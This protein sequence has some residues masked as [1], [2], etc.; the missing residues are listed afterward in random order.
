MPER[1]LL[2]VDQG[3]SATKAVI[4]GTGGAIRA[5]ASVEVVSSYPR[6]GFVEQ[7]PRDIHR[8]VLEAVGRCL[9][10]MRHEG[11][12]PGEIAACG[13]SNQRET[14]VLWDR[15]GEPLSPAVV[16]QC[17]RSV[18]I[19]ERLRSEGM[20]EELR[21]RTGL[22]IDP[23]FS[24]TKL[25]WL[26]ENDPAIAAAVRSGKAWFGTI[27][28]WLLFTLTRG[29]VHSTDYT[30]ASRTLLFNL[31]RLEWDPWILEGWG[32]GDLHLPQV[33]P[34]A[35]AYAQT[36][37]NGLLA[38]PVQVSAVIGDSH[39]AAFGEGCTAP[40]MA[41]ATIGTG[42]S[43]LMNV[44]SARVDSTSGMV[45]TI[46]WSVPGRLDHAL[47]GIIVSAGATLTWMRDQMGLFAASSDT[48]ALA[49][50]VAD[51]DGV[52]VVPAFSGL[53]APW[54][55]MDARA[56]ICGLTFASTRAHVVRAALESIPFQVADVLA[57]MESDSPVRLAALRVDGGITENRFVMQLLSDVLGTP[58]EN[59]GLAEVSALGAALLA[60]FGA[61]LYRGIEQAVE[62]SRFAREFFPGPG[63][64]RAREVY[65]EWKEAVAK[66]L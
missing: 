48:E 2:A 34:S 61:G 60:G 56:A 18:G 20:E 15:S 10:S 54:W 1:L 66:L 32:L 7:S 38:R 62:Q 17:R 63:S 57:S 8:S 53:G 25:L 49:V 31:D 22:R 36:D 9:D 13:I 11:G 51:S 40:G 21:R 12:D 50:S 55:R 35:F 42:S 33:R 14:F 44:G 39:A 58:V 29:A 27:D 26:L 24:A 41:K 47:E 30:N 28:S 52:R 45:S 43:I 5:R 19:C 59:P 23:Y 64:A 65:A 3:T 4:F 6:P 37:F 46:C 16:W